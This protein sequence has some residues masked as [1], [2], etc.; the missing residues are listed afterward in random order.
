MPQPLIVVN[1]W[2]KHLQDSYAA[3]ENLNIKGSSLVQTS[4]GFQQPNV[5]GNLEL[6]QGLSRKDK[7]ILSHDR[8]CMLWLPAFYILEITNF[9]YF[10]Y[11]PFLVGNFPFRFQISRATTMST[12][13]V[14][15]C[16]SMQTQRRRLICLH[17]EVTVIVKGIYVILMYNI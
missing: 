10:K 6:L 14:E 1:R 7:I 3:A 9:G 17:L 4:T 11:N 15:T 13:A 2:V 12:G 16:R 8:F 5:I